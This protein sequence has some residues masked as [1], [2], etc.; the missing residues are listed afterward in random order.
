MSFGKEFLRIGLKLVCSIR[1]YLALEQ[2]ILFV[3]SESLAAK[4]RTKGNRQVLS[5]AY[6]IHICFLVGKCTVEVNH[7]TIYGYINVFH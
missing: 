7:V 4:L 3:H 6:Y 2:Y 1:K 5:G